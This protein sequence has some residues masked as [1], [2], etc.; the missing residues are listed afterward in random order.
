MKKIIPFTLIALLVVGGYFL[1]FKNK[2]EK[3]Q[4]EKNLKQTAVEKKER[5][6]SSIKDLIAQNLKIKCTYQIEDTQVVSY[7]QGKDKMR[8]TVKNKEGIVETIFSNSK[9]Y[10]WDT[11]TKQ[12]MM[13]TFNPEQ[14]KNQNTGKIESP[15]KQ[16]EDLEKLKAQCQKENFSE[17]VFVPPSDVKFEDFDKLQE[18]MQQ[19]NF[20]IQNVNQ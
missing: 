17:S 4:S 13:M 10:T 19:G 7:F 15:E 11:K 6:T 18:M 16:I 1:V 5:L 12:G 8:N 2:K 14:F 3:T 9:I 20:Q